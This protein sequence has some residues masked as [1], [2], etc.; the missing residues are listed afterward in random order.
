MWLLQ[1]RRKDTPGTSFCTQVLMHPNEARR[2]LGTEWILPRCIRRCAVV[3][4][5]APT[6][7]LQTLLRVTLPR[8]SLAFSISATARMLGGWYVS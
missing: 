2:S 5:R 8:S 1:G 3:T 6:R 4:S 7:A